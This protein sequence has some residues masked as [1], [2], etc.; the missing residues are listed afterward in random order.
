LGRKLSTCDS[1][2]VRPKSE[3]RCSSTCDIVSRVR[4]SMLDGTSNTQPASV[5]RRERN[6]VVP[7]L[8]TEDCSLR[9]A[10]K[11]YRR[12]QQLTKAKALEA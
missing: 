5:T 3:S 10:K 1:H 12:H 6:G 2:L 8:A 4:V 7:N 9:M 11:E